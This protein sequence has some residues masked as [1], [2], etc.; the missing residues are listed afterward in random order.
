MKLDEAPARTIVLNAMIAIL[1]H[2]KE[3]EA[4][5]RSLVAL[6]TLLTASRLIDDRNELIQMVKQ[7]QS[8]V[9]LLKT[10]SGSKSM[11]DPLG[12]VSKCSRQILDLIV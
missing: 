5:F 11:L 1:P 8:T 12:K 10:I 4:V 7:S 9:E 3:T 2:L 6:G